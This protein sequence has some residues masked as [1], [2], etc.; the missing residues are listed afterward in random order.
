MGHTAQPKGRERDKKFS[1]LRDR[2]EKELKERKKK[3]KSGEI[4]CAVEKRMN[5]KARKTKKERKKERKKKK[6]E[7]TKER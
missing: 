2:E 1:E 6:N 5:G 4:W 3:K 7:R